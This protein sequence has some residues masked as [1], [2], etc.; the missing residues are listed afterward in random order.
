MKIAINGLGRI[1]R[2]VLR[3]VYEENL[4]DEFEIVSVNG[5]A[6]IETHAHL[7]K[8]DSLHGNFRKHLEINGNNLVVDGRKIPVTHE[9]DAS[10]LNWSGVDVVLEC[11]G[12]FTK[13][14]D[15]EIHIKQGARKVLISA[16]SPD[17][18][19]TIVYCVNNE[20]LKANHKI[21]SVGPE[22]GGG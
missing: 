19:A 13:K 4:S 6:A 18:E 1:G 22:G 2:Q 3:A 16:P 20:A 10:R 9:K 11:T 7:I 5:P 8:Y 17:A 21:I 14:A 12:K 15:A